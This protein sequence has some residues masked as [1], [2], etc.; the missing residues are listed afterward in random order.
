MI[1]LAVTFE[2]TL[3]SNQADAEQFLSNASALARREGIEASLYIPPPRASL[4]AVRRIHAV[5]DDLRLQVLPTGNALVGLQH[6]HHAAAVA[7]SG[8]VHAATLVYTRNLTVMLVALAAGHRVVYEHYRPWPVQIPPL[9]PFLRWSMRHPNFVGGIFHSNY[10]RNSYLGLGVAPEKLRTF[11]NGFDPSRFE[12]RLSKAEARVAASLELN[13][14]VVLY[15]G[16]INEKKGLELVLEMASR[17]PDVQFVLVGSEG[18][19]PIEAAASS[20]GNV[21]VR[22]WQPFEEVAKYLYAADVLLI[23]PSLK[24]LEDF[25][26]TVVPLKLFSYLAAGRPIVAPDAPDV[27]ELLHH[28]ENALLLRPDDVDGAVAGLRALLTDPNR[29]QRLGAGALGSSRSL[30]WT[31]RAA[32]IEEFFESQLDHMATS[33]AL[34]PFLKDS[35]RWARELAK[36]HLFLG[37]RPE[38]R[39]PSK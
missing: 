24:P 27:R 39:I 15:A 38:R 29:M 19:G 14:P 10:A 11:H 12:P 25:G 28:D 16:R 7:R 36:G 34:R 18:E 5:A 32:G 35:V 33:W 23:P 2:N 3:P 4:E 8:D 21:H 17:M 6:M 13:G 30:T 1:R 9:Q 31:R 22:A 37:P 26:C 20:H